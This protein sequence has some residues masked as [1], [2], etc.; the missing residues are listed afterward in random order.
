M[1]RS[2]VSLSLG[3]LKK[4]PFTLRQGERKSHEFAGHL[5]FMLSLPVLSE[6]EGVF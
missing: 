5:P 3:C 4:L 2:F 6:V 1:P